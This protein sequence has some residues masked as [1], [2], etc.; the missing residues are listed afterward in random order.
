M[1]AANRY[2]KRQ[3]WWKKTGKKFPLVRHH[4]WWVLHNVVSHPLLG[5][6]PTKSMVWFHDWTSQ[7]LNVRKGI[8]PSPMP[9]IPNYWSWLWHNSAGHIIIGIFPVE[10]SF[11]YHDW[12]SERM[13]V[14]H[15]L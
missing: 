13:K 15:W 7:H 10:A 8:R 6:F 1:G 4:F 11:D 2:K 14:K 5:L 9:E 12:T 3:G